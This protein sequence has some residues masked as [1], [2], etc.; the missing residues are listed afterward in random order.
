[1]KAALVAYED[2]TAPMECPYGHTTRIVTGGVGGV[3]NVHVVEVTEGRPHLHEGYDEVYYILSGAGELDLDG[4]RRPLR[5]GAV[6]VIPAGTPHALQ[7]DSETPLKF[8]IFGT[9]PV[10]LDDARAAPRAIRRTSGV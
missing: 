3:A 9:P 6:A 7:S 5:P 1:M 8:V 2:Q 10:P 4:A